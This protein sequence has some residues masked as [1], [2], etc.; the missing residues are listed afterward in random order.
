MGSE[1]SKILGLTCCNDCV[2]YVLNGC[3]I[4]SECSDC[5][6]CDISNPAIEI[7]SE[8]DTDV[9]VSVIYLHSRILIALL[10]TL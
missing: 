6:S 3:Q 8:D 5:F 10:H 9:E 7:P 4:H 1:I 2:K